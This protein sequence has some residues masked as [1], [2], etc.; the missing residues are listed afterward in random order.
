MV[1]LSGGVDSA[2][3][4]LLLKQQGHDVTGVFMQNWQEGDPLCPADQDL[5]DAQA[6][7][8]Q[9]DIPFQ[10]IQFVQEYWDKVFQYFLDEY[11]AGR[12]PNPDI[13]CNREIKFKAFLQYALAQGAD[14][15]ATGHYA[16]ISETE[17]SFQLLKGLDANKDQSY[18][19][20]TLQQPALSKSLFPLGHLEKNAVRQLAAEAGFK[21]H[22]KKDSTGICF[23]GER[24]FRE[25]LG[26][27]LLAR[28]G[29]IETE[30]GRVIGEHRG[31]MF[32]TLGQRQG[33]GIGGQREAL[34]TPW[35]VIAKDLSRNVLVVGQGHDHP[36]LLS[37][38]L[39]CE[40]L[41][42]VA[43]VE[44]TSPLRCS[45][46]TRY[47]QRDNP[48]TLTRETSDRYQVVFDAP[49]WAVTPGQSVVFYQGD[50]CLG[51]GVICE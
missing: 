6:V 28:P 32:Y 11:A 25:F 47:R 37:R 50:V 10:T 1:G 13:L 33:L 49:E 20:Y 16:R 26:E 14:Y 12:T 44:P 34:T 15:I 45:A 29:S 5:R 9:L 3:A 35:Y 22:A 27:Y 8:Q 43:G 51:G 42:W 7:C 31:L 30:T 2:V 36:R 48:C 24:K 21:N 41:S 23:I 19:L 40:Q 38:S 39:S 17:H 4:A 46:K 18:F